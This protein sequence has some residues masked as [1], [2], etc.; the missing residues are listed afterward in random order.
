VPSSVST[1]AGLASRSPQNHVLPSSEA[2]R[3]CFEIFFQ[4]HFAPDFCSFLYKKDF[5]EHYRDMPFLSISIVALCSRY[6]S[7]SRARQDYS[8]SSAEEVGNLYAKIARRMARDTSD[9]PTGMSYH[10]YHA[11]MNG[12]SEY[13]D[14]NQNG[15][16][17]HP[18]QFSACPVR[19]AIWFGVEAM[20]VRRQ[21]Y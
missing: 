7:P 2:L 18:G 14:T 6:L 21:C 11:I 10:H 15:S 12:G 5:L 17:E 19:A 16:A 3:H 4:R 13:S 20:D 1:D 9:Q 8:L